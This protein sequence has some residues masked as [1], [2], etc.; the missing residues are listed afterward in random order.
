MS[1]DYWN[2]LARHTDLDEIWMSHPIVRARINERVT[3]RPDVWPTGWLNEQLTGRLPLRRT[4]SIGCGIGNLERD[5]A[6][7]GIVESCMGV[8]TADHCVNEATSRAREAGFA[9]R[10]QYKR[11]EAR[12]ALAQASGLDAVFFHA[13]LHHF[14]RHEE[15][16]RL[17]AR[18]LAPGG[19]LYID[20]YVGPSRDEWG[21]T[22]LLLPN[23]AYRLMPSTVRRVRLIR[24]PINHDDPTE[25]VESSR[26]LPAI[27]RVFANV[28]R[29]DYGG[30]LLSLLYPSLRRPEPGSPERETLNRAVIRLLDFEETLMRLR[31]NTYFSVVLATA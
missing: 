1:A 28:I 12:E 9:D 5:L 11:A 30:N 2:D 14:D 16:L 18:A 23:L 8:D 26:I 25:A 10:L 20:E 6:G 31:A 27:E 29:R 24:A 19:V 13:S 22:K 15:L 4:M 3:G 17:V 7:Q 21:P